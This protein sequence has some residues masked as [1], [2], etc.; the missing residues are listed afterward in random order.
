MKVSA[1]GFVPEYIDCTIVAQTPKMAKHI[2]Q[3]RA[4]IAAAC[5]MDTSRVN[6]KAT[7]EER[8]GFTGEKLGLAAH[9]VCLLKE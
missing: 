1:A 7:T 2:L 6:V 9:A 5:G 3:M 4:N 8:M